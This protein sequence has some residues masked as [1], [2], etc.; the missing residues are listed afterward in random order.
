MEL[1]GKTVT[2]VGLAKS[3]VSAA[4]LLRAMGAEV[5]A[6]DGK[7][8]VELGD[9]PAT[10]EKAGVKLFVGGH[11]DEAVAG[12]SLVVTSPGVPWTAKPL[13]QARAANIPLIGELELAWRLLPKGVTVVAITGSNGKST[14]T[15]LTAHLLQ[16]AGV[17]TWVGGNLGLPFSELVRA[18]K[19]P[20]CAVVEVS[21]F[22]LETCDTFAPNVAAIL[23]VSPNHLDRHKDLEEYVSLKAKIWKNGARDAWRLF[24]RD[25]AAVA[26]VAAQAPGRPLSFGQGAAPVAGGAGY[27]WS[28]RSSA[29]QVRLE[30]GES[31]VYDL[32]EFPSPGAHNAANAAAAI[33]MARLAGATPGAIPAALKSFS[34]LEHRLEACGSGRGIRFFNDSKA[35]TTEAMSKSLA[36]FIGS[37]PPE[38]A[39]PLKNVILLAGG[40]DKGGDWAGLASSVKGRVKRV[41]TFGTHK[42][43]IGDALQSATDVVREPDLAAAFARA[44]EV[45]TSGDVVLFSPGCASYDQFQNFEDRGRRFKALVTGWIG[46]AS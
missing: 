28:T 20:A 5:R 17:D 18:G 22:M 31:E 37:G 42:D 14:T 15:T 40:K 26:R 45:A 38:M 1:Q 36:V 29:V 8:A 2:V 21:S 19:R 44:M 12:A 9:A 23:N 24:N 11:P 39:G 7:P 34:P 35:T 13:E 41:V 16:A 30:G 27:Q 25:D 43:L 10:L 3:G 32:A 46:G 6:T 4:L 33:L